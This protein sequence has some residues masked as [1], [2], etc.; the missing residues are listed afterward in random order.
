MRRKKE[1]SGRQFKRFQIELLVV[2]SALILIVTIFLDYL[3]LERSG[4]TMQRNASNLI[5]A[6]SRQ[7]ELNINSY[8]ER[9]E[10]VPTLLFSDE[11]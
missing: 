7:I 9:M 6:N 2:F 1:G 11:A 8:L 10:T 5:S 3:I 4:R